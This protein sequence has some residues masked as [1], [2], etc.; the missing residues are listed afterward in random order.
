MTPTTAPVPLI[1][2]AHGSRDP[3]AAGVIGDLMAA[4]ATA[5]PGLR[6]AAAFLDLTEPDLTGAMRQLD[7]PEVVVLPLLFTEAFHARVDTPEAVRQACESTG[8]TAVVGRILGLGSAVRTALE[9]R[10]AEAG[11]ADD[12]PIALTAVGSADE[13]ANAAVAAFAQDWG[14]RRAAPV[15]ACFATAGEP[16]VAAAVGGLRGRGGI[17]PLFLAPGLLLRTITSHAA[18]LP[19]AA[20]IGVL[21]ADLVLRRYDEAVRGPFGP[22]GVAS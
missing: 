18:G 8:S 10:A 3:G 16:K 5:R 2:L 15:T 20:P 6:T 22:P 21:L 4:V 12:A 11:I 7:A 14:T 17:V 19:V 1:G 13:N 9:V